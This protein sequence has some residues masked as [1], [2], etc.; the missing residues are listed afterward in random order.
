MDGI[1][2]TLGM[3]LLHPDL[4]SQGLTGALDIMQQMASDINK[5]RR[6][7]LI[8]Y[9]AGLVTQMLF[10]GDQLQKESRSWLSPPDPSPNYNFACETHQDGTAT[11]FFQGSVFAEWNAM[12]SLL[13]IYGTRVFPISTLW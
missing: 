4:G 1:L 13:W 6:P 8:K 3:F 10:L 12:S 2:K 9:V 11:W 7:L 5:I